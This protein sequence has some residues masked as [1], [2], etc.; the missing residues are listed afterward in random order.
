MFNKDNATYFHTAVEV[1][2]TVPLANIGYR[3][4]PLLWCIQ[5]RIGMWSVNPGSVHLTWQLD[6][7]SPEHGSLHTGSLRMRQTR[8]YDLTL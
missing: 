4:R 6:S 7:S 5:G 8:E 3:F 2:P 1:C